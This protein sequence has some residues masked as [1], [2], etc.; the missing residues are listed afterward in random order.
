[1]FE[2]SD[3]ILA[4]IL[5][6]IFPEKMMIG[7]ISSIGRNGKV[8]VIDITLDLHLCNLKQIWLLGQIINKKYKADVDSIAASVFS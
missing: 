5:L 3:L 4:K 6:L 2:N 1:M 8:S 7:L